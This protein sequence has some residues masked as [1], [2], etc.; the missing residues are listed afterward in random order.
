VN[1]RADLNGHQ[2]VITAAAI[3]VGVLLIGG[4]IQCLVENRLHPS[5]L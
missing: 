3:D 2:V 5:E 4:Q 1:Q